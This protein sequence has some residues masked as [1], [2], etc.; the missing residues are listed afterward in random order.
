MGP[1]ET[2]GLDGRNSTKSALGNG[3]EHARG[4]IASAAARPG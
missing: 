3:L 4:G 1:I 2:T